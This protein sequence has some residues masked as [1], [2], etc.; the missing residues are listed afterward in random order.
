MRELEKRPELDASLADGIS[1][2]YR[3]HTG[4]RWA[5]QHQ[6]IDAEAFSDILPGSGGLAYAHPWQLCG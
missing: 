2:G 3:M 5:G 4:G 6:V 1:V